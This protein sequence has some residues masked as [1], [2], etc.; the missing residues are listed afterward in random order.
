MGA[1][2]RL[3]HGLLSQLWSGQPAHSRPMKC[4]LIA[5][6]QARKRLLLA[7][8]CGGDQQSI[9][10][11][12]VKSWHGRAYHRESWW[13]T[14]PSYQRLPGGQTALWGRFKSNLVIQLT[15]L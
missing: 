5:T 9:G 10:R 3:L 14:C 2:E 11:L 13:G 1:E 12:S 7:C 6:H 8:Q 4:R 15:A